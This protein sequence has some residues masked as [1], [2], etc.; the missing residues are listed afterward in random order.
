[1][2]SAF[3]LGADTPGRVLPNS[4][5]THRYTMT[6]TG[7][8]LKRNPR[9]PL[10]LLE[11]PMNHLDALPRQRDLN[12]R[13]VHHEGATVFEVPLRGRH[14]SVILRKKALQ[15]RYVTQQLLPHT[16]WGQQK[17]NEGSSHVPNASKTS[18]LWEHFLERHVY[19][20]LHILDT[21]RRLEVGLLPVHGDPQIFAQLENQ[22]PMLQQKIP[23]HRDN[24]PIVQ[25]TE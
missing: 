6:G 18:L 14:A 21:T 8:N 12:G 25:A 15:R 7:R 17:P 9:Q 13:V 2:P 23:R 16:H 11:P 1:M 19:Q 20:N 4:S 24:Q 3:F 22:L 10:V 5:E